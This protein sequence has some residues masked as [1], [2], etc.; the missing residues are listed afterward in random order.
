MSFVGKKE[1]KR[2]QPTTKIAEI[3]EN[4]TK[5]ELTTLVSMLSKHFKKQIAS[6]QSLI[7][8][9]DNLTK[10]QVKFNDLNN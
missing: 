5:T 7:D 10:L 9:L 4:I 2:Q 1:T 6:L 8:N 3:P